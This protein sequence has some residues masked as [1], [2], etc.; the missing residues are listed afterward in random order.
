MNKTEKI[1]ALLRDDASLSSKV[2][3]EVAGCT[4]RLVRKVRQ[5]TGVVG[6]MPK[7]LIFD[8]E[9]APLEVYVWHLFKNV[10]QPSMVIKD[11]SMLSWSAK[12]LFDD[13]I[14]GQRVTAAEAANRKDE[15]ILAEL[16][17]MLNEADIVVA[18]NGNAFDIKISN[19]RFAIAG[20]HPPMPFKSVDTLLYS[21][22]VFNF[23]SHK[24]DCLNAYFGLDL[25]M[26]HEGMELWKKCV[27]GDP[28]ALN[29]MLKY[30]K[31]DVSILEELYLKIRP[32]LKGHPNVGLYIDT[33]EQLCSNCGNED[34]TW[35]GYY[36]TPAGKYKSFRCD[37]CGAIGRSRTSDLDKE[38]R[39]RLLLSAAA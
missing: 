21:R 35:G 37:K 33:D 24:L 19:A 2:I 20:L 17:K 10:V 15:S 11:R 39:A 36:F 26:E 31:R 28:A 9:T 3:A 14:W 1:R 18:H 34:L 16:W 38:T 27:N 22:K 6:N 29:K 5:E 8:I 13:T 32:W 30:N 12:W 4:K 25:K 7:I 23:P